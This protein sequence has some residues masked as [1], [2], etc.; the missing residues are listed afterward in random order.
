MTGRWGFPLSQFYFFFSRFFCSSPR[1]D[2]QRD[3]KRAEG[4]LTSLACATMADKPEEDP[5]SESPPENCSCSPEAL[6]RSA[7]AVDGLAPGMESIHIS[8]RELQYSG[9][10]EEALADL[11]DQNLRPFD[12]LEEAVQEGYSLGIKPLEVHDSLTER[13]GTGHSTRKEPVGSEETASADESDLSEES[14]RGIGVC[15]EVLGLIRST[16]ECLRRILDRLGEDKLGKFVEDDASLRDDLEVI[17]AEAG[18]AHKLG[19]EVES[20][21]IRYEE[22]RTKEKKELENSIRSLTEENSDISG[23]LRVAILE[24]E[25]AEKSLGKLTGSGEQKRMAI[26]QIAEWGLQKAG[27][28]F[29]MGASAGESPN[30]NPGSCNASIQSDGSECE[31]DRVSL[32]STVERIIKNLRHEVTE[33]RCS[34]EEYRLENEHLQAL[35]CKQSQEMAD[36]GLHI[37]VLEE[38]Q[39]ILTRNVEDLSL[40]LQGAEEEAI[41]WRKA[42]ELEVEAGKTAIKECEKEIASLTEDLVRT[43]GALD[44]SNNKLK[45]KEKLAVTAMAAQSAAE[46]SLRLADSRSVALRERIEELTRQLEEEFERGRREQSGVRRRVRHMC[47]PWQGLMAK[48]PIPSS[49]NARRRTLPDMVTLLH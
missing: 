23:L 12:P 20:K 44:T 21:F 36:S 11:R 17:L 41:R 16:K 42:C 37:K 45:L 34:L 43:R 26:F 4:H 15:S 19:L 28:G 47:W 40:E 32:A 31:E 13:E 39:N 38:K 25:A 2:E 30:D 24:K 33:L 48:P 9:M 3:G 7:T 35:T 29:M 5:R 18:Q 6:P 14:S 27:F 8:H 22:M 1:E 10:E 46:T 49:R